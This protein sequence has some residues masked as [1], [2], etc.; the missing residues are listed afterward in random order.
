MI[1]GFSSRQKT[2]EYLI[3]WKSKETV[4][5]GCAILCHKISISKFCRYPR[6]SGNATFSC[7][8][9]KENFEICVS[10]IIITSIASCL[11]MYPLFKIVPWKCHKKFLFLIFTLFLFLAC[12]YLIVFFHYLKL[13]RS[14]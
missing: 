10:N 7:I 13:V 6:E 3:C 4:R 8:W 11:L 2:Q 1:G 12:R 5:S 14:I 9:R